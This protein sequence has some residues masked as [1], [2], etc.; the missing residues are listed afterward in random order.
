M[1]HRRGETRAKLLVR[2][3]IALAREVDEAL[4]PAADL[5]RDDE[6]DDAA[7]AGEKVGR[8]RLSFTQTVDRLARAPARV[9]HTIRVVEHDD[10]LPALLDEHPSPRRV[11]IRHVT[12][13]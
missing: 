6:R 5:V 11:G 10:R 3:E 13:F 9:Q 1:R 12:R 8:E 7:L 2:G 4:A